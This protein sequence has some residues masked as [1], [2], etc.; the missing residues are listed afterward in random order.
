MHSKKGRVKRNMSFT[1]L[2]AVLDPA[3]VDSISNAG[4]TLVQ[5]M[6]L[7]ST[8]HVSATQRFECFQKYGALEVL[9]APSTA[10]DNAAA[11]LT[12]GVDDSLIIS[13]TPTSVVMLRTANHGGSSSA[14]LF[15][16]PAAGAVPEA[17]ACYATP[18]EGAVGDSELAEGVGRALRSIPGNS[19]A[20]DSR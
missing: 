14:G 8:L 18:P 20:V 11:H 4:Q 16:V 7:E 2:P 3:L 9:Q 13:S 6:Q 15:K 19:R 12:G 10:V 17:A 5:E 1:A